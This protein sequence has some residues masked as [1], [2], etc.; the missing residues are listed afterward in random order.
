MEKIRDNI[1]TALAI[2][3]LEYHDKNYLAGDNKTRNEAVRSLLLD[4]LNWLDTTAID[5]IG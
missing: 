4:C 3:I 2:L 1:E 5:R